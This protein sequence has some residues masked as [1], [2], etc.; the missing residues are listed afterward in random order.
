M[1]RRK[2]IEAPKVSTSLDYDDSLYAKHGPDDV[3]EAANALG[4]ASKESLKK[5]I[6]DWLT[7]RL[8]KRDY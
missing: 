8:A 5:T 1:T 7:T 6:L 2:N 4:A 3:R